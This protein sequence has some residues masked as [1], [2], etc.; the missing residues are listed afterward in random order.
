MNRSHSAGLECMFRG[1]FRRQSSIIKRTATS[2]FERWDSGRIWN[3]PTLQFAVCFSP[4]PTFIYLK[5]LLTPVTIQSC[6]LL[7]AIHASSITLRFQARIPG[8]PLAGA[9]PSCT[10]RGGGPVSVHGRSI[11]RPWSISVSSLPGWILAPSPSP[12]FVYSCMMNPHLGRC[13]WNWAS[14]ILSGTPAL[15]SC[16]LLAAPAR[17]SC[18]LSCDL[19]FVYICIYMSNSFW[20]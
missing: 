6:I 12:Y 18:T 19:R 15:E 4:P 9:S 11:A 5:S 3:F 13:V 8:R 1:A 7:T 10:S 17:H 20:T 2:M 16:V 14:Y